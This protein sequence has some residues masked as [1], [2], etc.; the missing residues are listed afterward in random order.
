MNVRNL[1]LGILLLSTVLIALSVA[2]RM[3]ASNAPAPI[4]LDVSRLIPSADMPSD[5][6]D[7]F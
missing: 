5:G 1:G 6:W 4:A 3:M 7:A 2:P